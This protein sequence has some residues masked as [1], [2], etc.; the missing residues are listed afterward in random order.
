M[1][2]RRRGGKPLARRTTPRLNRQAGVGDGDYPTCGTCGHYTSAVLA[3]RCTTMVPVDVGGRLSLGYCDC[4][5]VDDP[6]VVTWLARRD[7]RA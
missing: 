3:G 5:C 1:A 7:D 6:A 2:E 4:R